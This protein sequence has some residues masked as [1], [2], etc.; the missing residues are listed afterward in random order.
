M[1]WIFKFAGLEEFWVGHTF[2]NPTK[3]C[4][5]LFKKEKKRKGKRGRDRSVGK[6]VAP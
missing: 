5:L 1:L 3:L 2:F 6:V 4:L